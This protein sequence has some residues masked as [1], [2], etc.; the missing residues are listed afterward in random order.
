MR[1]RTKLLGSTVLLLLLIGLALVGYWRYWPHTPPAS[2]HG[3]VEQEIAGTSVIV[4]YIRPVAHGREPFGDIIA[5]GQLWTPS[6]ERPAFISFSTDVRLNGQPLAKGKY[7]IWS[8]PRKD[9]WT[10]IF[11]RDTAADHFTYQ[12]GQDALRLPIGPRSGGHMDTL[13]FY[14]PVVDGHAAELVLHWGQVVVPI[15]ITTP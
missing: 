2:Q 5:W 11:S 12:E 7:A 14:F 3:S 1:L 15:Q 4:D 13:C 6:A 8:Q 10:V 9:N